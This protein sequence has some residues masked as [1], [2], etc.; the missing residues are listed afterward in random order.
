MVRNI[1]LQFLTAFAGNSQFASGMNG[2]EASLD[3]LGAGI[4]KDANGSVFD[5]SF[6]LCHI[7]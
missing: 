4:C 2:G 6:V 7:V 3:I 1:L 5:A